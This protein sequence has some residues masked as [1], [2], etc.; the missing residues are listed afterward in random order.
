MLAAEPVDDVEDVATSPR[1]ALGRV[2]Q[3]LEGLAVAV[4]SRCRSSRAPSA[5][6]IH[7]PLLPVLIDASK[8]APSK[9]CKGQERGV[10]VAFSN[11]VVG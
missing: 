9:R 4:L 3:I 8:K 6:V 2:T 11:D 1:L 7:D 10:A 5:K